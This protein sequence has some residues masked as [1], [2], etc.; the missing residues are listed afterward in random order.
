[1]RSTK[2]LALIA[3]LCLCGASAYADDGLEFEAELSGDQEVPP[4]ETE[5]TGEAEFEVNEE[6]T[7]IKFKLK[8]KDT[9]GML[10][11]AG[12]H[13]HCAPA[14]ENGPIVVFLAGMVPGGFVDEFE[15]EA[16]LTDANVI[17]DACG[18]NLLELVDAMLAGNTYVNVHS[19]DFPAGEV[20]G[21]IF[22]DD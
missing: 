6:F 9:T 18:S 10:G 13:I 1:M 21:Q 22:L 8:V 15:A 4:V 20:R 19:I 17:N 16:V 11:A 2:N 12:A 5:A 3:G 7:E 14:G